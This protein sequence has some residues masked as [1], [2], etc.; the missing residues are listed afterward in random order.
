MDGLPVDEIVPMAF[1]MGA[2]D[3]DA[4]TDAVEAGNL[5]VAACRGS[6]GFSTDEPLHAKAP[7]RAQRVY[8]FNPR[9]WS[10]ASVRDALRE[11]SRWR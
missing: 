11:A 7:L 6:I 10:E 1:R 9:S 4:M 3:S 5:Q 8:L 2:D